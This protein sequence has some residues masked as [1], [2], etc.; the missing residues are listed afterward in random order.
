[1]F[2]FTCYLGLDICIGSIFITLSDILCD[3][4]KKIKFSANEVEWLPKQV[5]FIVSYG[6]DECKAERMQQESSSRLKENM[7]T[8]FRSFEGEI[9]FKIAKTL[10]DIFA[11]CFAGPINRGTGSREKPR[12]IL[13]EGPPGIGKTALAKEI[14]YSWA[15]NEIL[16]EIKIVFLLYLRDPQLQSVATTKQLV[17]YMSI[18][19]LDDEQIATFSEHLVNTNGQQLCIV[20]DGFNE[21]PALL[22]KNSFIADII[23]S[24]VLS[25]ATVV[26]TSRPT[27]TVSLYNKVDIRFNIIGFSI[28]EQTQYVLKAISCLSA[29]NHQKYDRQKY[30]RQKYYRRK[31]LLLR[32]YSERPYFTPLYMAVSLCLFQLGILPE[33]NRLANIIG[34]FVLHTVY[35]H[36]LALSHP[37]DRLQ[38]T[39][40]SFTDILYKLSEL[41]FKGLQEHKVVFTFDEIKQIYSYTDETVTELGLLQTVEPYPYKRT[42]T[43]QLFSFLHYTMQEFLAALHVSLLSGEQQSSLI[44]K[45]FWEDRYFF[46]WETFFEMP[47]IICCNEGT[48]YGQYIRANID[49]VICTVIT[50]IRDYS[51]KDCNNICLSK[52]NLFPHHISLLMFLISNLSIQWKTLEIKHCMV[53]HI[54]MSILEGYISEKLSTVQYVDLSHNDSTPWGVYCAIIRHCS[55]NNLALCGIKAYEMKE[56]VDDI[57]KSLQMNNNLESLTLCNILGNIKPILSCIVTPIEFNLPCREVVHWDDINKTKSVLLNIA[58]EYKSDDTEPVSDN[59]RTV[60]V[61]L[62]CHQ[63]CDLLITENLNLLDASNQSIDDYG[64]TVITAFCDKHNIINLSSNRISNIGAATVSEFLKNNIYLLELNLSKNNI[65]PN[66]IIAIAKAIQ[67]NTLLQKFNISECQVAD[68]EAAAIGDSLKC[69]H[70]L[71]ELNLSQNNITSDGAKKIAEAIQVNKTLQ[72]LDISYNRISDD[73]A[74]SISDSLKTNKSLQ[75]LNMSYNKIC[76]SGAKKIAEAIQVNLALHTLY[77]HRSPVTNA[78]DALAF[79]LAILNGVHLNNTLMELTLSRVYGNDETLVSGEVEKIN[80]QRTKQ[81]IS[82]LEMLMKQ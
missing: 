72:K 20:M 32:D 30:D 71:Q 78:A 4:Y 52:M 16:T 17:E 9:D 15:T 77:L 49:T 59:N 2:S 48:P 58:L 64:V 79:N 39:S 81:G 25:K 29:Y 56:Y 40:I 38:T 26:I 34:L 76:S 14:A 82:E 23:N 13:I 50:Q 70:S 42:R 1:M 51:I 10:P 68:D 66:G 73:G 69:N 33:S 53:T 60:K 11:V 28:E 21:Y 19:Y 27:A 8:S 61:N 43:N 36:T 74:A 65:G 3:V 12:R 18:G 67:V 57:T 54:G 80:K 55:G 22:Q 37:I 24:T 62:L 41:A 35:H 75:V 47:Y 7:L 31:Y 5:K 46:M 6:L 45:T 44:K 63:S